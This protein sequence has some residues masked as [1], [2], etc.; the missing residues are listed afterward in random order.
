MYSFV[1]AHLGYTCILINIQWKF[2]IQF[3][4][5]EGLWAVSL[6]SNN[7]YQTYTS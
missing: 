5:H 7:G 6:N 1:E 3:N 2:F 4:S